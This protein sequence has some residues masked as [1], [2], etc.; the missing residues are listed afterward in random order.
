MSGWSDA[1]EKLREENERNQRR[2]RRSELL[3]RWAVVAAVV[4]PIVIAVVLNVV[5]GHS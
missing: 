5:R 1:V 3:M 4:L 2:M